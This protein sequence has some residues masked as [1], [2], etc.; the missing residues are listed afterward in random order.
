MKTEYTKVKIAPVYDGENV[1]IE[2]FDPKTGDGS[3]FLDAVDH[4]DIKDQRI[5]AAE[6]SKRWNC[7]NELL[8]A[9]KEANNM[10]EHYASMPHSISTA[11]KFY[12][13]TRNLISKSKGE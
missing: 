10:I 3:P 11:N 1:S 6:V 13:D 4:I 8:E 5:I 9:L 2:Y 7:H 12:A